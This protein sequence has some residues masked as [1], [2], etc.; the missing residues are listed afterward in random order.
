MRVIMGANC[1]QRIDV[2][3]VERSYKAL[4]SSLIQGCKR[5]YEEDEQSRRNWNEWLEHNPKTATKFLNDKLGVTEEMSAK[6]L[7]K[8]KDAYMEYYATRKERQTNEPYHIEFLQN[9]LSQD[10]LNSDMKQPVPY[11]ILHVSNDKK[12]LGDVPREAEV[13][14][15]VPWYELQ[16]PS[17]S[18]R[19]P[20]YMYNEGEGRGF[21]PGS[22]W[23]P[24]Y[25][26]C[27]SKSIYWM[28]FF[29]PP[30]SNYWSCSSEVNLLGEIDCWANDSWYDSLYAGISASTSLGLWTVKDYGLP[31]PQYKESYKTIFN[32]EGSN[33]NH[34]RWG[35][36]LGKVDA[37]SPS[38]SNYGEQHFIIVG[39]HGQCRWRGQS[40]TMINFDK[41]YFSY[42]S[43]KNTVYEKYGV[44]SWN[45]TAFQPILAF[46]IK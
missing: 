31:N 18:D 32:H 35:S 11:A 24:D 23:L 17:W 2:A 44:Y 40:M 37:L 16:K 21:A 7:K 25:T 4:R 26:S 39:V 38:P 42:G 46:F 15:P 36:W 28:Y 20:F 43:G 19:Q 45:V 13:H 41:G 30:A 8:E 29:K 14:N 27:V 12:T 9:Q 22:I 3:E 1:D 34:H 6:W 33:I 10:M 5:Q